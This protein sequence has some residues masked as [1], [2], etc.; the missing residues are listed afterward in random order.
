MN[1]KQLY[2]SRKH[3]I[4]ALLGWLELDEHA[5]YAEKEGIDYGHCGD[6]EHLRDL[7]IKALAFLSEMGEDDIKDAL[8][9]AAAARDAACRRRSAA[10][11]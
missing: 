8:A 4:A 7:L 11:Q 3:D 6:L 1:P 10:R 5:A 2:M 9:D